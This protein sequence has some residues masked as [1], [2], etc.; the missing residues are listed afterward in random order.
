MRYIYID[1]LRGLMLIS[2]AMSHLGSNL[3]L[4][5]TQTLVFKTT[6]IND[7][8]SGFVFLSGLSVAI[9]YS[10]GWFD[11]DSK[12]RRKALG[13]RTLRVFSHHA[14]LVTFVT[15]A[16]ILAMALG[17]QTWIVA[18]YGTAP[19]LFGAL[20][21]ISLA[22]GWCLDILPM[23][24][25][26][27][28]LT[29][30]ALAAIASGRRW[31]VITVVA[32]TWAIGQTGLLEAFWNGLELA[33]GL[34][35]HNI[36][37]GLY[38]NRLSWSA[39]YF[40]GLL[41]GSA[42]VRGEIDLQSLKSP[43]LPPLVLASML[44]IAASMLLLTLYLHDLVTDYRPTYAWLI[45]KRGLGLVSLMNVMATVFVIAWL[46]VAGPTSTYPSMRL[47]S[48]G[49][50]RLLRSGPLVLLGQHSLSIF[51]F[52]L[53]G[54][55]LFYLLVDTDGI[56]PLGGNLILVTGIASLAIPALYGRHR[57]ANLQ[58][59]ATTP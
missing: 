47:L 12:A 29:H 31:L 5:V 42:F 28:L 4:G 10:N 20:S 51:T 55:Y 38:F 30:P 56:D 57:K 16:A 34:Q 58:Q 17:R 27:L 49:L 54:I 3:S 59:A 45:S 50:S 43:K 48:A 26:F 37:L 46:L 1:G 44:F 53:V 7:A 35:H 22:A 41:L 23:Y 19:V 13:A 25:L 36:E 2:M 52:H 40:V 8:S 24:V 9:A 32:A 18:P 11:P 21:I 14:F 33:F 39:L 15:V 6:L